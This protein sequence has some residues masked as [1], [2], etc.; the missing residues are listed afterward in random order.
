[1]RDSLDN[2]Y[3]EQLVPKET[4]FVRQDK[5]ITKSNE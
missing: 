2:E 3:D 5:H 4:V 1:M